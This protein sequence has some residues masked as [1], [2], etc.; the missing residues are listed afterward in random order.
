[1]F[2]I[3][4]EMRESFQ[5]LF[6]AGRFRFV[7]LILSALGAFISISE[8]LL[9]KV[10]V[11]IVTREDRLSQSEFLVAGI[12]FVALFAG[13]LLAQYF[14]RTF[15]VT[16]QAKSFRARM[17]A[18]NKESGT[19]E[20][21]MAGEISNV[22]TQIT[23][24]FA[25]FIFLVF[26]DPLF[27][28]VNLVVV[29]LALYLIGRLFLQQMQLQKRLISQKSPLGRQVQRSQ[30]LRVRAGESGALIS[31]IATSLLL[32]LLLFLSYQGDISLSNTL[33]MF[34]GVRNQNGSLSNTSRSLMRYAKANAR[35]K[36]H[37]LDDEE[38]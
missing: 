30:G 8:L 25:V 37:K 5:N 32:A 7:L 22:S 27:A 28:L 3:L 31:G 16:A 10:F 38:L 33:L 9:L 23:K 20:W 1:M 29:S 15:R 36:S 19:R 18:V 4:K 17:K 2:A 11:E 13:I 21:A 34:F 12:V 14:Q 6:P 26:L 24:L 35:R